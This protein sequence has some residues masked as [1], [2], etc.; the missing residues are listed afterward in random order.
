MEKMVEVKTKNKENNIFSL[1][2]KSQ[3][4]NSINGTCVECIF[5]ELFCRNL[6]S[7]NEKNCKLPLQI[8]ER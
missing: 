4:K 2:E 8:S 6:C 7:G 3:E 5:C 1:K